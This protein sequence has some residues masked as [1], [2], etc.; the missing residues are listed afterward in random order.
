VQRLG[1]VEVAVFDWAVIRVQEVPTYEDIVDEA[2]GGHEMAV[3]VAV[4][5]EEDAEEVDRMEAFESKYNFRFEE[6]G[7]TEIVSYGRNVQVGRKRCRSSSGLWVTVD[8]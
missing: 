8:A 2:P 4:D 6:D 5:D 1:C 3:G 7:G